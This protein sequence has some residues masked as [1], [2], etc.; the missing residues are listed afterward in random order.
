MSLDFRA[1]NVQKPK[2]Y[3]EWTGLNPKSYLKN[4][5]VNVPLHSSPSSKLVGPEMQKVMR[6]IYM[7]TMVMNVSKNIL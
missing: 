1:L 5:K 3:I 4:K 6:D 7:Y 2:K